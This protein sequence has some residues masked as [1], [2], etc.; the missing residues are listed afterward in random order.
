[1]LVVKLGA[2]LEVE[3]VEG[4]HA[5]FRTEGGHDSYLDWNLLNEEQ[6]NKLK[7]LAVTLEDSVISALEVMSTATDLCA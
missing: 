5:Y 4:S 6:Q 3:L 7:A 2:G 1:M